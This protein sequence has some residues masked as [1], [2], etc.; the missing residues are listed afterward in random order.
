MCLNAFNMTTTQGPGVR[1]R[2]KM[3]WSHRNLPTLINDLVRNALLAWQKIV[4]TRRPKANPYAQEVDHA[5]TYTQRAA[6]LIRLFLSNAF[7]L[8]SAFDHCK[9]ISITQCTPLKHGL[10]WVNDRSLRNVAVYQP[11]IA[12]IKY[13]PSRH[14]VI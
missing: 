7:S 9:V 10:G 6:S 11:T 12:N 13:T 1:P 8:I 5:F 4:M 2:L 14:V 3:R